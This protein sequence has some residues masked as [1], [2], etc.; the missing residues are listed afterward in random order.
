M[1]NIM[2]ESSDL[3]QE[4]QELLAALEELKKQQEEER[5]QKFDNLCKHISKLRDEAVNARKNS[6]FEK[7]WREDEEFYNGI[8]DLN[9]N[10]DQ[11]QYHKPGNNSDVL[12]EKVR[13]SNTQ[14]T[15]FL[16]IIAPF[17]DAAAARC[18]DILLPANDWNFGMKPTPIPE[19]DYSLDNGA[20]A[21]L[22]SDGQPMAT[23]AD[24]A[25]QKKLEADKRAGKA[26]TR[27]RDW[28]V[29]SNYKKECRKVIESGALIGT[30]IL[31]GPYPKPRKRL[32]NINGEITQEKVLEPATCFVNHW[33]FFP[34]MNC[35]EYINDGDYVFERRYMY[36]RGLI[37]LKGIGYIDSAIDKVIEEGPGKRN[38][39]DSRQTKQTEN[40]DRFE[41]WHCYKY[42]TSKDL[43]LIDDDYDQECKCNV[44][45]D[46]N[47]IQDNLETFMVDVMMVNDTI[48]YGRKWPISDKGFPFDL[49]VWQRVAGQPFGI[50][51]ARQ[52][53]T[54]Q[55]TVLAAYRT[56]MNNQGLASR[57][58]MAFLQE[59]IEPMDKN[60]EIYGGKQWRIKAGKGVKDI[61]EAIQSIVIPS[62]QADLA[63]LIQFGMKA[64]EEATSITFLLQGQQG[65][66]P[67]TVRGMQM[68]LQ[69]SS[70]LLR[71]ITRAYDEC[72]V[73]HIQR[74]NAWIQLYG[75]ED[76]K[77]DYTVEATGSSSLL[78]REIQSMQL[79]QLLQFAMNPSFELSPKKT[80]DEIIKAWH[81]DPSKFE[82]D[83]SEKQAMQQ[84]Q[85]QD[86]RLMA[87]QLKSQTQLQIADKRAEVDMMK[88]KTDQDRDALFA[89]GVTERNQMTYESQIAELQLRRELA[90]L[91]YANREK[92]NL[93]K[94]KA[95]LSDSAMKLSVQKELASMQNATPAKQ[96][97][98]PPSEPP[99]L[100]KK[101][102]AFQQ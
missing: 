65:S 7:Q 92:T 96:V 10:E 35:G 86:P 95:D 25:K 77:G 100:A 22:G 44:D 40:D 81:F 73:S 50:G 39:Q 75:E 83:E 31:K 48:I 19:L 67:D 91:E 59:A 62:L 97:I 58:M 70:A 45:E 46:G 89:Q 23:V 33:N 99:Q 26:E 76:E 93:D 74:Y 98:T 29:E 69:S 66:A 4:D 16:N 51:V 52:G 1:Q 18:G 17:V 5:R 94:I 61:R 68:M 57:P 8:D 14:C 102:M 82:M 55:K 85:P 42:I 36:A 37:E 13:T 20:P 78:E 38:I 87:E 71:R 43:R 84:A 56:L 60:W 32:K 9:R 15:A 101:G 88:I 47:E 6:G 72:T 28:L 34:D 64:M 49:F 90:M 53:R 27:I 79:P 21:I 30:G 2:L 41:V 11:A 24:M 3:S 54:P 80:I 12:R 63:A